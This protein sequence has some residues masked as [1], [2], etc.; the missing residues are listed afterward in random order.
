MQNS[1]EKNTGVKRDSIGDCVYRD[2]YELERRSFQLS[3]DSGQLKVRW[4]LFGLATLTWL[5]ARLV[6]TRPLDR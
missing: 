6:D 5:W 3:A 1:T 4:A 2:W